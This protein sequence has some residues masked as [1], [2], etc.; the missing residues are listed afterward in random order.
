MGK[1]LKA[2]CLVA[3]QASLQRC[4]LAE[5]ESILDL[6]VTSVNDCHADECINEQ[7][8]IGPGFKNRWI[9]YSNDNS[10]NSNELTIIFD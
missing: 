8:V 5:E 9:D 4:A 10:D 2:L 6:A 1:I 3:T 7:M